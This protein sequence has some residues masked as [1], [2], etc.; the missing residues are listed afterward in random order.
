[1]E[2]VKPHISKELYL[3]QLIFGFIA[4]EQQPSTGP[5]RD[6]V[7]IIRRGAV[8]REGGHNVN[9]QPL[10]GGVTCKFMGKWGRGV[11]TEKLTLRFNYQRYFTKSYTH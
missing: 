10:G 8:K 9:S 1:M 5:I 4:I 6:C 2:F 11:P 3:P 7:I